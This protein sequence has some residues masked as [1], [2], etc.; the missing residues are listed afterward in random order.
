MAANSSIHG[1]AIN[2][3]TKAKAQ[4]FAETPV[5]EYL[6]GC[7]IEQ[8][9]PPRLGKRSA[10]IELA[11]E[12]SKQHL[13]TSYEVIQDN[14]LTSRRNSVNSTGKKREQGSNKGEGAKQSYFV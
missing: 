14:Y 8:A 6:Q 4:R 10:S 7:Q 2:V 12:R 3:N 11:D 13:E 1:K 5:P 9:G